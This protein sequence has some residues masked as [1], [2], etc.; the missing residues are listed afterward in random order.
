M[1]PLSLWKLEAQEVIRRAE[2]WFPI[3][4]LVKS[5]AFN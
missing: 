4:G 5:L 3:P 2:A 1:I